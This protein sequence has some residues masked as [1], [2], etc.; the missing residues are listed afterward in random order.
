MVKQ[1]SESGILKLVNTTLLGVSAFFLIGYINDSKA[2]DQAQNADIKGCEER[3]ISTEANVKLL[4]Q[5]VQSNVSR[6]N[7]K[8]T[9][10]KD[11]QKEMSK[12]VSDN[13]KKIDRITFLIEQM[14]EKQG[15]K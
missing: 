15:I 1:I 9:S 3:M 8:L 7:E 4:E 14:A 11:T 2:Q 6:I 5:S 12:Q 13:S 10:M